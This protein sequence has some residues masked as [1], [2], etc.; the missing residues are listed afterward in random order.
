MM[1][2]PDLQPI[3]L[4]AQNW[5]LGRDEEDLLW[6]CFDCDGASTNTLSSSVLT[7][8]GGALDVVLSE[9]PVGLVI[10][11]DKATGFAAG[12]DIKEFDTVMSDA[13]S[14]VAQLKTVHE[15][16][17]RIEN[18][19]F[20]S[21]ACIRGFCLGGGLELALACR[22]RVAL[23]ANSRFGFPEVMLGIH[24]GFGGT[25]RSLRRIGVQ[26]AMD[27]MLTGR[28]LDA[29]R[30]QRI[31][32]I[33]RAVPER[34]LLKAARHYARA[35]RTLKPLGIVDGATSSKL[36]KP[37]VGHLIKSQVAKR[38]R[39]QHY[40]APYSVI[41]LWRDNDFN[42]RAMYM[43]EARSVAEL[44]TTQT[45]QNL[46]R[47]FKLQER[48][49]GFGRGE[50]PK[51]K[52][53][54]VVGAGTMGGD[55]AAWCAARGLQV[56]LQDMKV[57]YV[58]AAMKRA[59]K[60]FKRRIRD[61]YER[62]AATDRLQ[63]DLDGAGIARADVIIEAI[64]EDIDAKQSLFKA[65]ED[66]AREDAILATNTSSIKLEDIGS[67]M[68]APSRL[69]GIHFFNPVAQMQ[70]VEIVTS[71]ATD[72]DVAD[73]AAAFVTAIDRLPLPVK[74]APGFLVNRVLSPYLQEAITMAE[75]GIPGAVIDE[76]AKN[77][78]MPMGPLEMADTVGL[79]ICLHVGEILASAFGGEAPKLLREKVTKKQLGIKTGSGFF[80]YKNGKRQK[81]KITGEAAAETEVIDRMIL[82][83]ANSAVQVVREGV[84]ADADLLDVGMVFGSGFAPFRGGPIADA[85]RRGIDQV[86]ARMEELGNKH[87]ERFDVDP[88]W[89]ELLSE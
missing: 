79:D 76:A 70:L 42:D 62:L 16:F 43:A 89:A 51:P 69:V 88:G 37:I 33:D 34:Q 56:T 15:L 71:E 68:S 86:R 73:R 41:N 75:E 19:T 5:R 17:D 39:Q 30:A 3:A 23:N 87:G 60:L 25:V 38:A 14:T 72:P 74:S 22:H 28:T 78:G 24:P 67:A 55:I 50:N 32:L 58:G 63:L 84:V 1:F 46:V 35:K 29:H 12:A 27:L 57:E 80:E 40:P 54:H 6:L 83:L 26:S 52:R 7:E 81:T 44:F 77:F 49:K 11:S 47:L 18:L 82:R 20:S 64:I 61:K 9:K 21:V 2:Y 85:K 10:Y 66:G 8:L 13:R 53:V 45:S 36:A 65:L 31:G 4:E 48:L 59:H